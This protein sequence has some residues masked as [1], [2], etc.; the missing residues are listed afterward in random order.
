MFNKTSAFLLTAAFAVVTST[1]TLAAGSQGGGHGHMEFGQP[2][3]AVNASRTIEVI[4]GDNYFEPEDVQ[5]MKGETIR[6]VIK[7]QG[8]AVHEFNIGTSHMH[9]EHQKEMELMVEHGVIDGDK[10]NQ[11][12]MKMDMGHGNTMQHDDPNSVLLEPGTE[13]EIVW[14]FTKA[15]DLEFAC[16]VPGHYDSGMAGTFKFVN[17]L[18]SN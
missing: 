10:I 14:Q 16:N 5:I 13:A 17:Q 7:N 11:E 2:G 18:A 9:A 15:M 12:L 4:M 6:F 3:K 8:D 1:A